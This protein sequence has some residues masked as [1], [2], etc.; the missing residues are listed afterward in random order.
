[1]AVVPL[2]C[3]RV[4]KGL[5]LE[6]RWLHTFV[7][8]VH[9]AHAIRRVADEMVFVPQARWGDSY[10]NCREKEYSTKEVTKRSKPGVVLIT[11]D[12]ATGSG[13]VVRHIKNQ[14]LILTNS[15]VIKGANQIT[16]EWQDGNQDR[17]IVVLD[18]GNMQRC[19]AKWV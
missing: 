13:F 14:T 12:K 2:R 5:G 7:Q 17:A 3:K 1:M 15:H 6:V 8:V 11:T 16:V 18:G 9:L 4:R 19:L 10:P